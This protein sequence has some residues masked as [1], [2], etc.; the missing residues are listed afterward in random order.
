MLRAAHNRLIR[1]ALPAM[2]SFAFLAACDAADVAGPEPVP[3]APAPAPVASV[4]IEGA[5]AG[6]LVGEQLTLRAVVRA[7]DGSTLDRPVS[8]TTT[9]TLRAVISEAGVLSARATGWVQVRAAADGEQATVSV[10]IRNRTPSIAQ[11]APATAT[12]GDTAIVLTVTGTGFVT[13]AQ[14]LWNGTPRATSVISATELRASIPAADLASAGLVSVRVVNPGENGGMISEG[15]AFTVEQPPVGWTTYVMQGLEHER[16]LPVDVAAVTWIDDLGNQHPAIQ[17][18]VGGT[19]RIRSQAGSPTQWEEAVTIATY[20]VE[21]GVEVR[22]N[23]WVWA[24]ALAYNMWDGSFVFESY[25]PVYQSFRTRIVSETEFVMFQGF[26][27]NGGSEHMK[28]WVWT[29]Q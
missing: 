29:K 17:R 27:P 7:A 8:W 28:P 26:H 23:T 4:E 1:R 15:L 14:V 11:L 19:L 5:E 9:D 12:A 13:G 10:H 25:N 20:L 2:L 3:P 21:T 24:G 22:R 18:I 6:V 16:S